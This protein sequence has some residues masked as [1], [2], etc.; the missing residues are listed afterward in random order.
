ML[1]C[2]KQKDILEVSAQLQHIEVDI[3]VGGA[4]VTA[5]FRRWKYHN[6]RLGSADGLDRILET[7]R[8]ENVTREDPRYLIS[9]ACPIEAAAIG[10]GSTSS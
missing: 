8:E 1:Q 5:R 6:D 9:L 2:T 10:S 7:K 4:T 3:L